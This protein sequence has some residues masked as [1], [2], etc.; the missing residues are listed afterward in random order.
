MDKEKKKKREKEE[1]HEEEIRE[2]DDRRILMEMVE[3]QRRWGIL[4][5][6]RRDVREI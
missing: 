4:E 6:E 5:M 3:L 2:M 1:I